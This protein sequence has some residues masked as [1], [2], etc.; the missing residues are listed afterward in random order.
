MIVVVQLPANSGSLPPTSTILAGGFKWSVEEYRAHTMAGVTCDEGTMS[1]VVPG[2]VSPDKIT[3]S[4]AGFGITLAILIL[5][6]IVCVIFF[7][8]PI[9]VCIKAKKKPRKRF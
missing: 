2:T 4:R 1:A 9:I 5:L 6:A 8:L 3:I 7:L